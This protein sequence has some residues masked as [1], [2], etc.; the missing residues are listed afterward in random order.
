MATQQSRIHLDTFENSWYS[1][2]ANNFKLVIWYIINAIIFNSY[3]FPFSKFKVIIL[4]VFGAGVGKGVVIKPRVN[5]KHPWKL[6]IAD[7]CWIGEKVWIDNLDD[8]ILAN[9]VCISQGAMLLCGNH[10]YQK[11][12]FDLFTGKIII[13]DGVWIGAKAIV[14]PG[15]ICKSHSVL[16]V[17][18]IAT[19]NLEEYSIY[20]GNP[21]VRIKKRIIE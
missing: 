3:F 5:I 16:T 20:Q 9:N 18:S 13:E 10:N 19:T 4:K 14:C 17:G 15:V 21:A 6:K 2:G 12:T 7:N 1:P 11:S 8:I